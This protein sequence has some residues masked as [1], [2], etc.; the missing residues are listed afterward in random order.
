MEWTI[1]AG[2]DRSDGL[3]DTVGCSAQGLSARGPIPII[4]G[5]LYYPFYRNTPNETLPSNKAPLSNELNWKE[6]EGVEK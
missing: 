1:W 4:Y 5:L 3:R 2:D 6:V